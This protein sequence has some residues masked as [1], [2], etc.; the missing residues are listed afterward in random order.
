MTPEQNVIVWAR[1]LLGQPFV[2]GKTDCAMLALQGL[3]RFTGGDYASRYAGLWGSKT[4]AL[5]HYRVELP[6]EVLQG[7]GAERVVPTFAVLGDVITVPAGEWPEQMHFVLGSIA[8]CSDPSRGVHYLKTRWLADQD[9]A[10]VWRVA[11]C[12]RQFH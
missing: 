7:F 8:L 5:R 1:G 3:D 10:A 12:R 11:G 6:S 9:G 2:W 4:E